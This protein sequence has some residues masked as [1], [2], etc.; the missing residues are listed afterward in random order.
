MK[1]DRAD[2]PG[3]EEA[4]ELLLLGYMSLGSRVLVVSCLHLITERKL[5]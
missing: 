5:L 1:A 4:G 2:D 3:W